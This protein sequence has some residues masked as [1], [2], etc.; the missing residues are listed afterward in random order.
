MKAASDVWLNE[1][2]QSIKASLDQ[3]ID[4]IIHLESGEDLNVV[5]ESG[6]YRLED[7]HRH[8]PDGANYSNM[9][10]VRGAD[11]AFQIIVNYSTGYM[12]VRGGRPEVVEWS[13][14]M[15]F[16]NHWDDIQYKPSSFVQKTVLTSSYFE[17]SEG[18]NGYQFIADWDT[19]ASYIT[20]VFDKVGG[21]GRLFTLTVDM[22]E[23]PA[24]GNATFDVDGNAIEIDRNYQTL[25]VFSSLYRAIK[26][27]AYK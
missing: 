6:F 16:T 11:T 19:I 1:L 25:K 14:W 9:I 3:K 12:Y 8:A 22:N 7:N 10:V 18:G 4:K 13:E 15:H 5:I 17:D 24:L 20:I 21:D 2:V 23:L 26:L 27:Y